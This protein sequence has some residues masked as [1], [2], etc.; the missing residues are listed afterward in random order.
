[1]ITDRLTTWHIGQVGPRRGAIDVQPIG[2]TGRRHGD[3]LSPNGIER[4]GVTAWKIGPR[5]GILG[6]DPPRDWFSGGS[7]QNALWESRGQDR[8]CLCV[9]LE[10][11]PINDTARFSRATHRELMPPR[12][13]RQLERED[14]ESN[15]FEIER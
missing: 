2:L 9:V 11:N 8:I 3:E 7:G 4:D 6:K 15:D 13:A 12:S 10:T 1:R 14:L 5:P